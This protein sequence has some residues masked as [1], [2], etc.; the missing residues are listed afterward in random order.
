MNTALPT[1]I[2]AR[3]LAALALHEPQRIC[4]VHHLAISPTHTCAGPVFYRCPTCAQTRA[5]PCR[6]WRTLTGQETPA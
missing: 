2:E 4:Q 5:T 1:G 3:V 6:T